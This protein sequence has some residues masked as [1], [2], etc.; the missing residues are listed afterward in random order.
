MGSKDSARTRLRRVVDRR[1]ARP[2]A[3]LEHLD[4]RRLLPTATGSFS[5]VIRMKGMFHDQ[6]QQAFVGLVDG[7]AGVLV[8]G[9]DSARK[10][11]VI[12]SLRLRSMRTLTR[13]FLSISSSSQDPREGIR[14]A[15]KAC[16]SRSFGSMM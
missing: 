10:S 15:V 7:E 2:G 9:L 3:A 4:Q 16:L 5:S 1:A 14:L 11:V 8:D 12:G 13:P 6:R